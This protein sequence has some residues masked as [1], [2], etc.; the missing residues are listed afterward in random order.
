MS[1]LKRGLRG[2]LMPELVSSQQLDEAVLGVR[3]THSSRL[4]ALTASGSLWLA[5]GPGNSLGR[6]GGHERGGLVLAVEPNGSLLA[7]GGQDGLLRIWDTANGQSIT[8]APTGM[9]WVERAAWQPG[10]RLIA[11]TAGRRVGV[12]DIDGNRLG[13][14]HEH[15][16]TVADLAWKPD[17]T[18]IATAS[19][20]GVTSL[21]SDGNGSHG[22]VPFKGS[23]LVLAWQP[24]GNFLAVGN[25]DATVVF[26]IVAT[27]ETLQMWGFPAKVLAMDWSADGRWLATAAGPGVIL[28]DASGRGPRGRV[29]TVLAGHFGI[30]TTLAW[31]PKGPI[32]ASGG[33]DCL[34][35]LHV[36]SR[37]LRAAQPDS[38]EPPTIE[39]EDSVSTEYEVTALAWTPGGNLLAIG[40]RGGNVSIYRVGP[41]GRGR[42]A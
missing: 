23:S 34:V 22:H 11:A 15:A 9:P 38:D 40:D 24:Q 21:T 5:S 37:H 25:Q 13:L 42:E 28:W 31:Q 16:S 41:V 4:A 32:L 27:G 33:K 14:S 20:G 2:Q 17:G 1:R 8:T 35:C 29:P 30:A 3:F 39:A 12:W 26:V 7:S 19:Y 36:P 6:L 10:G 18:Q